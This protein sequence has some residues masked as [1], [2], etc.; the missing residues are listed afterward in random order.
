MAKSG[1]TAPVNLQ[2]LI[3]SSLAMTDALAKL[4]IEKGLITQE[5][6]TRKLSEERATYQRLLNPTP[7]WKR[8]SLSMDERFTYFLL[9]IAAKGLFWFL[10]AI[11]VTEL[12][13]WW[14]SRSLRNYKPEATAESLQKEPKAKA[15]RGFDY[16]E[17]VSWGYYATPSGARK[18]NCRVQ[19][20]NRKPEEQAMLVATWLG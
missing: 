13:N 1:K 17:A 3:V 16:P 20:R 2:E 18:E 15:M 7:Q 8:A 6:F 5:E 11:I 14:T 4:L 9:I 19:P 12:A 10:Y